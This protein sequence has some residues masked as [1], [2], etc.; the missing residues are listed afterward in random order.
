MVL[1]LYSV[2]A[3]AMPVLPGLC[4]W[5]EGSVGMLEVLPFLGGGGY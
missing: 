5:I 4:W 1:L 3:C 2:A